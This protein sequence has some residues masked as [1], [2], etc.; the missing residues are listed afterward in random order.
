DHADADPRPEPTTAQAAD[1]LASELVIMR[2]NLEH[3]QRLATLGT[4]AAL[5]A[6]E[7]NNLLTPVMSYAQMALAK[8]GD[9]ELTR[10][11]LERA[12]AGS[13][14]AAQIAGTILD[15]ARDDLEV[16]AVPGAQSLGH[17]ARSPLPL[18]GTGVPCGTLESADV[19]ECVRNTL[20]CLARDPLKDGIEFTF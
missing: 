2:A 18:P 12:A 11:A 14:K 19:A 13:E 5:I 8:P 17:A 10:K 20:A 9:P 6:H 7:F 3:A 15:F 16:G 1:R 4:I